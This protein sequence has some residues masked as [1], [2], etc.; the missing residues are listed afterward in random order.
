MYF[1]LHWVFVVV[2]VFSSCAQRAL[3]FCCGAQT[4]HCSGF[5]CCRARALG[6]GASV[7]VARGL[8][9]CGS[10]ALEHRLSSCGAWASLL[11]GMWDPPGPGLKPMSLALTGGLSTTVSRGKSPYKEYYKEYFESYNTLITTIKNSHCIDIFTS[12]AKESE[13]EQTFTG[14]KV[15]HFKHIMVGSHHLL[16]HRETWFKS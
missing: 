7:V 11:R 2:R 13:Q 4:S 16:I 10:R 1:W 15:R 6:A 3:L 5:S 8:S 9:S 14:G 12:Y